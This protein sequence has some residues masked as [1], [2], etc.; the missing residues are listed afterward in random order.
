MN[1][2]SW[3]Y[4]LREAVASMTRGGLMSLVSMATVAL[5]LLVLAV[6][7]ILAL[8]LQHAAGS[9]E[10]EVEIKLFLQDTITPEAGQALL[11]QVRAMSG[12]EQATYR[13]KDQ[14]LEEMRAEFAEQAAVL[15][16]LAKNPLQ[17]EID[18][19]ATRAELVPGLAKE[20]AKLPGVDQ[21]NYG[22]GVVENLLAVTQAIRLGGLGMVG[23]LLVATVFTISN[24]IRLAVY[25]RRREIGIMKLV[26][27]TDAFIRR[28]FVLEGIFLGGIG[29]GL[30]MLV[31]NL[32]YESLVEFIHNNMAFMPILDTHELLGPLTVALLVLGA[33]LG[34]GG[35]FLS[36]RRYLNV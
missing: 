25:A 31:T 4:A 12:V 29:A 21:V 7:L 3:L 32:L 34:A 11:T 33:A 8:N 16:A 18:V 14:A 9:L 36:L 24:T 19:K 26:G 23:L 35:S 28:P 30:A 1:P 10:K 2:R 22:Q 17:D 27:A 5:S 20:L 13:T 6:V 15:D